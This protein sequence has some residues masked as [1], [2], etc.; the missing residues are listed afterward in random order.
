MLLCNK[1]TFV[2]LTSVENFKIKILNTIILPILLYG[3]ETRSLR[4]KEERRLRFHENK[5]LI[6]IFWPKRNE[7][8]EWRKFH[9][10]GFHTRER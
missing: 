8:V 5:T 3:C 2:F 9:I 10:D 1:N 6:R 7:N 4:F